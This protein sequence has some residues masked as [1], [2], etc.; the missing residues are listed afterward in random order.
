[1][2]FSLASLKQEVE[3]LKGALPQ[4]ED[5]EVIEARSILEQDYRLWLS[6]LLPDHFRSPSDFALHHDEYWR[7]VWGIK[8]DVRPL[9]TIAVWPREGMKSTSAEATGPVLSALG[10]RSYGLYIS[11]TQKKANEHL[12]VIRDDMLLKSNIMDYY[13]ELSRPEIRRVDAGIM[14]RSFISKWNQQELVTAGG[15]VLRAVGLDV[16]VRGTRRGNQRP[17]LEIF[18]DIEDE[19]DGIEVIEKKIQRIAKGILP[20]GAANLAVFF[21]QN[22][23]HRDS[24]I[25]QILDGRAGILG[26]AIIC[27]GVPFRQSAI[28]HTQQRARVRIRNTS[29]S[30]PRHGRKGSDWIARKN[31]STAAIRRSLRLRVSI[32]TTSICLAL[33]L[34]IRAGSLRITSSRTRNL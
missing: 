4:I 8:K 9:P 21:V 34:C 27:G 30:A 1:M 32:S 3:K 29:S 31:L 25:S 2:R 5:P 12:E 15:L 14:A 18:D 33:A 19:D 6:K 22:L 10:L 20:A 23:I 7:I 26:D 16:S 11:G 13:P 17:D 28:S 24:V